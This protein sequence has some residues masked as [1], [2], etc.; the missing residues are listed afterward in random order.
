MPR[1]LL[2]YLTLT[3]ADLLFNRFDSDSLF[4]RIIANLLLYLFV[5]NENN[6]TYFNYYSE[7]LTFDHNA[8]WS[9]P[10]SGNHS[11]R[12]ISEYLTGCP[13]SGVIL[14]QGDVPIYLNT[15]PSE[16][17]PLSHVNPEA[18]PVLYK[19]HW[20]YKITSRSAI[21]LIIRDYYE[22]ISQPDK[23]PFRGLVNNVFL[24][25]ELITAYDR[26][27][28]N[29]M[30]IYYEDLLTYPEREISRIK[31][32]L[33]AS[34]KRFQTLMD[35]YDYY[36]ELSKQG[37]NRVW[38]GYHSSSD[39]R[40]HQKKLSKKNL[41]TRKNFFQAMLATKRYQCVKPYIARYE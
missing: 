23:H 14:G 41:L 18:T 40:F 10:R 35:N 19:S 34:D 39:L 31:Y 20:A 36:A 17:H 3:R 25:L 15:F 33:N 6:K 1:K 8:L 32:F 13:T 9:C 16:E 7:N 11:V 29:K 5:N 12:F 2:N 26:F 37:E 38:Y 4:S 28:G 30:I 24:Y 22:V 27:S 21:L